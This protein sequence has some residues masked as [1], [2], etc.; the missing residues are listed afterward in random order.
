M[1]QDITT[2]LLDPVAYKH[3]CDMLVERYVGHSLDVVA[4]FEARSVNSHAVAR[5]LPLTLLRSGFFF[6]PTIALALGLP[7]VPLRKPRK[8]PGAV[9]SES[10]QLEYGSD[11]LEMHVGA[12]QPG[13]RVLLVDDLIATGGTLAA[14]ARLVRRAG[15]V[16]IEACC[17]VELP[18]LGGRAKLEGLEV[19]T[20]I[21]VEGE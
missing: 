19:F 5:T 21:E 15:G 11:S 7:F 14:G 3:C 18:E 10:Y 17:V 6:G 20:L 16:P 1:F 13:Q 12:V 2:L 8:L 4:G 9:L